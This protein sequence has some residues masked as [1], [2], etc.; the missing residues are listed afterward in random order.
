MNR[1]FTI[2]LLAGLTFAATLTSAHAEESAQQCNAQRAQDFI[3]VYL[4]QAVREQARVEARA[5]RVIVNPVTQE[6]DPRRLRIITDLDLKI[7]RISC[8]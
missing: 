4:T 1:S 8:G 7:T 2:S 3:G 6:F 5:A